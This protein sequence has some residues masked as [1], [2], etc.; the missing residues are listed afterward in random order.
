MTRT[1][2]SGRDAATKQLRVLVFAPSFYPA[3]DAGGPARALTNL[4]DEIEPDYEVVV[5][6][7]DRDL[8]AQVPFSFPTNRAASRGKSTVHYIDTRSWRQTVTRTLRLC[9]ARYDIVLV[10]SLWHVRLSLFPGLLHLVGILRADTFVLMPRGELEPGALALEATKK[11]LFS[12]PLKGVHHL[13]VDAFGATSEEEVRNIRSWNSLKPIFLTDDRPDSI[14]FGYSGPSKSL[15]LLFLG[16]IHPTKGLLQ[17]IQALHHVDVP[18]TLSIAGPVGTAAYWREC[19]TEIGTLPTTVSVTHLGTI[20]REKIA[21][22]LHAHDAMVTLTAGENFGHTF[23][24]AL[25]A[26]CPVIATDKTPW[27]SV[28]LGGGGWIVRDRD[29][30]SEVASRISHLACM[31]SAERTQTRHQARAAFDTWFDQRPLNIIE[32]TAAWRKT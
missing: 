27:T 1:G 8:G 9:A 14:P 10:N 19:Q 5:V 7:P 28:I 12:P 31:S 18:L 11:R 30:R 2:A 23:A 25:Q 4:V 6:T 3:V 15:M 24:E 20:P 16:R 13:A 22:L 17:L 32:Q 29:S 21:G 26:G